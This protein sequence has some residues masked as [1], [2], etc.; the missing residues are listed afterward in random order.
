MAKRAGNGKRH[1]KGYGTLDIKEIRLDG[2]TQSRVKLSEETVSEFA[3]SYRAKIEFPPVVVFWDGPGDDAWLADG[4]HRVYAAK[5]VGRTRIAADI[6]QGDKRD[7]ILYSVG[8]NS[9]HGLRRTNADKRKAVTMLLRDEEWGKRSDRWIAERCGVSAPTVAATRAATAKL[10]Q[11]TA[12][13][14]QDGRTID[15]S[16]IGKG[17]RV[18]TAKTLTTTQRRTAKRDLRIKEMADTGMPVQQIADK[19]GGHRHTVQQSRIRTD[20]TVHNVN[21]LEGLLQNVQGFSDAAGL[22]GRG[23][24]GIWSLATV[25]QLEEFES[26]LRELSKIMNGL[27]RRTKNE[28]AKRNSA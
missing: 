19:L 11:S 10:L 6:R 28:I 24:K 27:S 23:E 4:F 9:E 18:D 17:P 2:G 5:R 3:D 13:A 22:V 14:G 12:R 26:A 21:P 25:D 20:K 7:A 16:K 8:A 15:I 1:P